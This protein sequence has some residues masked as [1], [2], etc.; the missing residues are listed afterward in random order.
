MKGFP[1]R[2]P[3]LTL[4][5]VALCMVADGTAFQYERYRVA[6]GEAWRLLTGQMV[7]WTPRTTERRNPALA[8]SSLRGATQI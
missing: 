6:E 8:G 4:T 5:L 7:H 1:W 2:F 3:W